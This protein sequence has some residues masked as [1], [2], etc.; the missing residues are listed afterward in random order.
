MFYN[1]SSLKVALD[2]D[3]AAIAGWP[4][5][6]LGEVFGCI[7]TAV[8]SPLHV[9]EGDGYRVPLSSHKNICRKV[10]VVYHVGSITRF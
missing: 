6:D 10:V 8:G 2:K 4:L 3:H 7:L 1:P 5:Q 9:T